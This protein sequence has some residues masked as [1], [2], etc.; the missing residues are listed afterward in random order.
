MATVPIGIYP[1]S[2]QD[3][4]DIPLDIIKPLS[5]ILYD[6]VANA[7]KTINVP[8]TVKLTYIYSRVDCIIKFNST[9]LPYPMLQ[10]TIYTDA[11]FIPAATPV[12]VVVNSGVGSILPLASGR[13]YLSFVEQ[14]ASLSQPIQSNIG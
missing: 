4:R 1:L 10:D 9:L 13:I 14:W 7:I 5:L 12:S 8:T 2:T 6:L 3:G 11:M